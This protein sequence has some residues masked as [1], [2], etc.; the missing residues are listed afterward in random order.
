MTKKTFQEQVTDER[1]RQIEELGYT[2][3]HDDAHGADRLIH[4]AKQHEVRGEYVQA[5]ALRRAADDVIER[6]KNRQP[7]ASYPLT[8]REGDKN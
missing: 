5:T 4:M 3:E 2:A 6:R 1:K 8:G 7:N